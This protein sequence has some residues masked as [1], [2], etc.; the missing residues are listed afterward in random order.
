VIFFTLK[1]ENLPITLQEAASQ[2][3]VS[4]PRT[5][6]ARIMPA[7][8]S[9]RQFAARQ[10]KSGSAV[11]FDHIGVDP[12]PVAPNALWAETEKVKNLACCHAPVDEASHKE[13]L[14]ALLGAVQMLQPPRAGNPAAI[15][16]EIFRR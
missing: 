12:E 7:G 2:A 13:A 11:M 15:R 8:R 16:N 9:P 5:C 10:A 4:K 6:L 1:K 14:R 3:M